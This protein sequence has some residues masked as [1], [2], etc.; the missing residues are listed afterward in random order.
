MDP[1]ISFQKS[2]LF[3]L[4]LAESLS[5]KYPEWKGNVILINGERIKMMSHTR[6]NVLSNLK[7]YKEGRIIF[8]ERQNILTIMKENYNATFITNQWCNDFNYATLELM[9]CGFPI[10]HNSEGWDNIGYYYSTNKWEEAIT[11]LV[12]ILQTHAENISIYNTQVKSLLW[13]HSIYNPDIQHKWKEII[14]SSIKK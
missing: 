5:I 8:K 1:T 6:N 7:L 9:H 11:L 14:E 10:L 2:Y 13:H 12:N 3:S 4:L